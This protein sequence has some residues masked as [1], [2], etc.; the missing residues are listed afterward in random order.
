MYRTVTV[1]LQTVASHQHVNHVKDAN[2]VKNA[3]QY[4]VKH[5]LVKLVKVNAK[6]ATVTVILIKRYKL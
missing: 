6:I 4:H 1:T 2:H 3:N 5:G